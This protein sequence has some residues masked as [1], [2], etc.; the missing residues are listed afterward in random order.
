[1]IYH[2]TSN[3][4]TGCLAFMQNIVETELFHN[5][6][7]RIYAM[8]E[9]ITNVDSVAI[10]ATADLEGIVSLAF[11]ESAMMDAKIPYSLSLIHISEPTRLR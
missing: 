8:V 9:K 10:F 2:I 3:Q 4:H 5:V 11:L 7:T 1:M 6:K